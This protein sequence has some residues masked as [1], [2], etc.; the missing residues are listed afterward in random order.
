MLSPELDKRMELIIQ[1]KQAEA[2]LCAR[3]ELLESQLDAERMK[4]E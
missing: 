1:K 3:I 4:N 2:S